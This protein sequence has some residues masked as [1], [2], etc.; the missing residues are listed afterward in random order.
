TAA[1]KRPSQNH[2]V[3]AGVQLGSPVVLKIPDGSFSRG[4]FK[5]AGDA[6]IKARVK[7]LFQDSAIVL[8][9][10]YCPTDFDWRIGVLDGEPLFAVQY[11]MA[12]KHWQ[13]VRHQEGKKSVEGGFKT[14]TLAEAPPAVI[15][16][17]VRAARLIGDGFYG[18]DMKVFGDRAV[19]IEVNDNPNL[20]HGC[21]DVAEKDAVWDQMIRWFVRRL[22]A[23]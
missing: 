13:I 18:V 17:A 19:V 11:L 10:E 14:V 21:E 4:V 8:A 9:Q 3:F 1:P 15:D 2:W 12:K 5:E 23:R 6:E 16:I 7:S 22:E 20:D